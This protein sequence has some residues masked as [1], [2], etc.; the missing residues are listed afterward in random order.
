MKYL[1]A[2]LVAA[3]ALCAVP[4]LAQTAPPSPGPSPAASATP[5]PAPTHAWQASG[6]AA[7]SFTT[8]NSGAPNGLQFV[9]GA[10]GRVFDYN[11]GQPMLN[12]VNVQ[13]VRNGTIGGK[14]ELT[15]GQNADVIASYPRNNPPISYPNGVDLTQAYLQYSS[16]KITGIV[17]KFETL[18]GAEV[19]EDPSNTNVSRSIL[20]GY[21]VPFT[22]TGVRL[23]FA[24]SSLWNI[25]G[26]YNNGWDNTK[27]SGAGG[28]GELGLQ[29]NGA[30][31]SATMAVYDGIERISDAAWSTPAGS[32]TGARSL[33]D[34]VA[35]YHMGPRW[36]VVG[37]LDIGKQHNAPLL[38]G[39]GIPLSVGTASWTGEA[40][41]LN[42]QMGDRWSASL[43]G[44]LFTDAG[45][46]R[47]TYDQRWGETT[48]TLA[49]A[50]ST[51]LLFR[52]EYRNDGNSQPVWNS[53]SG[54]T[55]QNGVQTIGLQAIV[56]F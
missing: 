48:W 22:H 31:F 33:F 38:S 26:G 29:Y 45:G 19:I 5:S 24:P 56:K 20:F 12:A 50:P 21:A 14:L 49:Y 42:Y 54:G 11:N 39:A 47:T 28:T 16:G 23:T 27:G 46:Y 32:P 13:V 9:D 35:T 2:A 43:R 55:G 51:P 4:A 3:G 40:G 15:L 1:V 34:F 25:I 44:E 52:F 8:T 17:G 41:Y 30:P 37:N 10:N 7:A 53:A 36:S 18:A 6:F